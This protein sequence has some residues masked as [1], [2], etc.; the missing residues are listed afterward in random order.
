MGFLIQLVLGQCMAGLGFMGLWQIQATLTAFSLQL[1]K[2]KTELNLQ[3][4]ILNT[5]S[6]GKAQCKILNFHIDNQR[7]KRNEKEKLKLLG[8]SS[9]LHLLIRLAGKQP[10]EAQRLFWR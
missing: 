8:L 5:K 6:R 4:T 10:Q 3:Q 7:K 9:Y 1:S 2:Q